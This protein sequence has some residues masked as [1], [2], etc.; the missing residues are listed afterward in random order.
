MSRV[1]KFLRK[2][3]WYRKAVWWSR[4]ASLP[5]LQGLPVYDVG[6]FFIKQL[7]DIGLSDRAAAISFNIIMAL[8]AGLIF[9]A[10]LIP[11]LPQ[12]EAFRTE[13]LL[14]LSQV[15]ADAGAYN[16]VASIINDFFEPGRTQ[17]ISLSVLFALFFS[18]NAM[19]GI[20]DTFDRS[21]F[22]VR[23]DH[24][25][26]KR[27]TALKLTMLLFLLI[28]ASGLVLI[29]QGS[30]RE[31]IFHKLHWDFLQ[32]SM[33]VN[34][35]RW[36]IVFA[37]TYFT[38]AFIY[39]F[40]P[41]TLTKWKLSSPGTV[42]A[43]TMM[44]LTTWLFSIW[45]TNFASYNKVYG[46]IGTVLILLNLVY[47]NSLML[48]IGFEINVSITSIKQQSIEREKQLALEF[49]EDSLED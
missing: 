38:L 5:G 49:A 44:I 34:V 14:T 33:L 39:R 19:I 7:R 6:L 16:L 9:V 31:Y 40:A 21:Y 2:R 30:I 46:S 25:M 43:T 27:W 24:F 41:A 48:I 26:A 42:V 23:K 37:L 12:A 29:T 22:E 13:M 32:N 15:I 11:Y 45:V 17:L 1:S 35:I 3:K 4:H 8:P 47:I 20:M 36:I 10:T 28:F 18:S